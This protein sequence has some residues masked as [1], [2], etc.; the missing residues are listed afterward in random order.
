MKTAVIILLRIL[1][2]TAIPLVPKHRTIDPLQ[3]VAFST[4]HQSDIDAEIPQHQ[5]NWYSKTSEK[6][7]FR[8]YQRDLFALHDATEI[9]DKYTAPFVGHLVPQSLLESVGS[10]ISLS[11]GRS[12]MLNSAV[13]SP[14]SQFFNIAPLAEAVAF[15]GHASHAVR[16]FVFYFEPS[17]IL[18]KPIDYD[19]KFAIVIETSNMYLAALLCHPACERTNDGRNGATASY[20]EDNESAR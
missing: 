10:H 6:L 11:H 20:F 13:I 14:F 16:D 19:A 2:C 18:Q 8:A 5:I 12:I 4:W 17:R 7:V 9:T 1:L 15:D 3:L